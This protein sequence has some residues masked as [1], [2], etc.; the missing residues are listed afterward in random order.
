[1]RIPHCAYCIAHTALRMVPLRTAWPAHL[2]SP[3]THML[4]A[5]QLCT[6]SPLETPTQP[7]QSAAC[8]G[9][10]EPSRQTKSGAGNRRKTYP[11]LKTPMRGTASG[12][13]A[14]SGFSEPSH[15]TKTGAGNR[16]ISASISVVQLS[17]LGTSRTGAVLVPEQLSYLGTSRT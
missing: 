8:S 5:C 14:R 4:T 11:I 13:A 17:Y 1:M 2:H 6:C 3:R 16:R 12:S 9:N 15:Q 7:A 10:S